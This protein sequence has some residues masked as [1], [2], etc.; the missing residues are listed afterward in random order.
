MR[1]TS[2]HVKKYRSI[3]DSGE[4]KIDQRITTFVGI[5][6]S[7]KTNLMRALKK[8]NQSDTDFD[9]LT[10]NPSWYFGRFNAEENFVITTFGLNE[11]EKQKVKEISNGKIEIDEVTFS[12]NKRMEL[13]CHFANDEVI[14]FAVFQKEHLVP[15]IEI[16]Q[17]SVTKL[18]TEHEKINEVLNELKTI[19]QSWGDE[20]NIRDPD[21][22]PKIKQIIIDIKNSLS[23]IPD[24]MLDKAKVNE[25]LNEADSVINGYMTEKVKTYLTNKMPRFIYF[26]NTAIIDSRIHLPTFVSKLNANNL[27]E[28]EKTA[29]TLLDIGNLNAQQLLQLGEEGDNLELVQKNKDRLDLI[30]SLAS[31]KVSEEIDLVWSQNEHTIEFSA[32][33]HNLR[34]WVINKSDGVKLQLEERSRGYQWYFSFYTIFNAESDR[35]HKDAIILLDEPALFL[36]TTGQQD[37]L[38]NILPKL[39]E[40]NQILYTTH[41]P[42]MVDLTKPTS[43]HTVTLKDTE[44]EDMIQKTSHISGEVWDSDRDALFPLQSALHYTMAQSMFIGRKNLLVEGVSDVWILSSISTV[45]ESVEKTHL[46]SNFVLVPVGG[47]TRSIVFASTYASQGLDVAVLLDA[48]KEGQE[49]QKLIV[50][51]RI[52]KNKK[53][54]F[55]NEAFDQRKNMSIEDLFPEDYYL[56]FVKSTYQKELQKKDIVN[57]ILN[58][59][60]PMIV[61]RLEDFF[62]E[63]DLGDFNKSRPNRAIYT[64]LPKT[65][66]TELPPILVQNFEALFEKINNIMS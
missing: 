22:F 27:D 45:F 30:T 64:E 66:F 47:A 6:E 39:A 51:N 5:N 54:L 57:I 21:I 35:G 41:S 29:K 60:D 23:E 61:K 44:I 62:N 1:L 32:R 53:I 48:D 19:E 3:E 11:K 58:S 8:I 15:I 56:Q 50:Q 7:G 24:D 52:L 25:I 65:K 31:K 40:K 42:F 26:E 14:R 46:N 12:K 33:G 49:S 43:I 37:F 20:T 17:S 10:E 18:E 59:R 28:D 9:E 55:M 13:A 16:F 2:L 34:V 36:H 38:K 4:I 63:K